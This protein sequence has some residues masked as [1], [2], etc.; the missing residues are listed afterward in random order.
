MEER[1]EGGVRGF[2]LGEKMRS[3]GIEC[4]DDILLLRPRHY[5]EGIMNEREPNME[6]VRWW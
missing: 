3:E 1:E 2:L 6:E 4:F 5:D